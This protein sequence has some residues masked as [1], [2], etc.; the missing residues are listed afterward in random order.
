MFVRQ[1]ENLTIVISLQNT[2]SAGL[3]SDS[4]R[5]VS[6]KLGVMVE[7]TKLYILI[8]VW[9]TLIFIHGFSLWETKNFGVHFLTNFMVGLD[10]NQF[11]ATTCCFV[12]AHAKF[13]LHK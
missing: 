1:E 9:M 8:S 2:V 5:P 3:Y 10:E 7:T 6:F 12:E 13:I 11:V 4:Y